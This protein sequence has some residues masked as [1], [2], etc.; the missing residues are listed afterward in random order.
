MILVV[1]T[2]APCYYNV[3]AF[4][5]GC[6]DHLQFRHH[7]LRV[8]QQ[9]R[10]FEIR[11]SSSFLCKIAMGTEIGNRSIDTVTKGKNVEESNPRTWTLLKEDLFLVAILSALSR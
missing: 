11:G 6:D 9:N 7:S 5:R 8:Q 3:A 10:S 2:A 1:N 4:D